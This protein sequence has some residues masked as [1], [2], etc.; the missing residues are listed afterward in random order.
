MALEDDLRGLVRNQTLA[1]LEPEALRRL[2][3]AATPRVLRANEIL[4]RC[5]EP[6]DGGYFLRSGSIA[7]VPLGQDSAARIVR[8]PALIGDMAL[9][10]PTRR[11]VTAVAYE[12]ASLLEI[13]RA[14]FQR[15]LNESP[16][17]A[18]R[19]RRLVAGRLQRFTQDLD[20]LRKRAFEG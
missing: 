10:A 11:P 3:A 9:I 19:L 17:S 15:V 2:V 1:A 12:L 7:F 20:D 14:L 8:P 16:R 18:E 5:D 13:P 6:S 4:F